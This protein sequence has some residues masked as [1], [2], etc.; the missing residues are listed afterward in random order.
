M[1]LSADT[2]DAASTLGR[3]RVLVVDD[4]VWVLRSMGRLLRSHFEVTL[5]ARATEALPDACSGAFSAIVCDLYMLDMD[6]EDFHG[7]VAASNPEVADRIVFL[8]GASYDP[9]RAPF[10]ERFADRLLAKPVERDDLLGAV[11]RI[12]VRGGEL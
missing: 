12:I 5:H 11:R 2:L 7:A 8:T 6:G 1:P 4:D 10:Y 9:A 3:P